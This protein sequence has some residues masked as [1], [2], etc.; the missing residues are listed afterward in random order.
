MASTGKNQEAFKQSTILKW[1]GPD[2]EPSKPSKNENR[3][4]QARLEEKSQAG[5]SGPQ[6]AGTSRTLN[7]SIIPT[8]QEPDLLAPGLV[9]VLQ[10][11]SQPK[12]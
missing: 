5:T 8:S 6:A 9:S 7:S 10:G 4:E 1:V 2:R 3:E 11:P 12:S